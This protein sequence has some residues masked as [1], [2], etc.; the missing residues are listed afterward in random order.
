MPHAFPP[1][2]D[3]QRAAFLDAIANP[4]PNPNKPRP[5]YRAVEPGT[6]ECGCPGCWQDRHCRHIL[7]CGLGGPTEEIELTEANIEVVET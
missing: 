5:A 6:C 2:T 1:M 7:L 3:E 4:I